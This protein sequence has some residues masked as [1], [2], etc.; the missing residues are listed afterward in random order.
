M[1]RSRQGKSLDLGRRRILS[2]GSKLLVGAALAPSI[3]PS[4]V[5]GLGGKTAPSNRIN[6]GLV[7]NGIRMAALR[8]EFLKKDG[9]Q[10]VAVCDVS[11]RA[12]EEA[13]ARV[14]EAYAAARADGSFHGCDA[15]NE[16]ERVVERSDIDA[17][18]IATPD[19]WHAAIAIAAIREGKDA[20]CEA[21]LSL[22]IGEG[23]K[24]ADAAKQGERIVQVGSQQRSDESF[25]R[26]AELVR[27]G[28]IGKVHTVYLNLGELPEPPVTVEEA[29]PE[30]LDY[31]R[32]LGPAAYEPFSKARTSGDADAGWRCYWDY[33]SRENSVWG[34]HHIDIVQWA[35]G[36]DGSGP[37]EFYPAGHEGI[38]QPHFRYAD[39]PAVIKN[40]PDGKEMI[41]FVGEN[42]FVAVG[43]DGVL[44]TEPA[45][46]KTT[47]PGRCETRLEVSADHQE[48]FLE[49][50]RFRRPAICSA[51]VGH[52]TA[53]ICH[54]LG[55][56]ERLNRPI[57]WDPVKEQILGDPYASR[58][59]DQPRR[60]PW[61]L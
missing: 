54:L 60:S 53:S 30:G 3:V 49:A 2:V 61:F 6:V 7:G 41:H 1:D 45:A 47:N 21:P 31:D 50:I 10:V 26:A 9:A 39:G 12:R 16:Y 35:L 37:T 22:T 43:R 34:A 48:N 5:L 25:R 28:Q 46:L 32:W 29:V 18:V 36:M 4:S 17:V 33:C 57:K 15:Y 55:I 51:E 14:E 52:R 38:A 44:V 19:H 11:A 23:R 27:N 13:K 20:Y 42:G 24:V 58:W 56:T 40:H 8:G 59:L